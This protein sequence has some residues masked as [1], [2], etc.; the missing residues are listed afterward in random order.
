MSRWGSSAQDVLPRSAINREAH[1]SIHEV[2]ALCVRA[3]CRKGCSARASRWFFILAATNPD[4]NK[5]GSVGARVTITAIAL[6][7]AIARPSLRP[8]VFH[9]RGASVLQQTATDRSCHRFQRIGFETALWTSQECLS[10]RMFAAAQGGACR[11]MQGKYYL[12]RCGAK[13]RL[14]ALL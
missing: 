10:R 11:T 1:S 14:P 12:I 2:G 7:R 13:A 9:R 5:I 3:I 8:I 4:R 6:I